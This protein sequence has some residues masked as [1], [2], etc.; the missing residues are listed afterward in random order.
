MYYIYTTVTTTGYGDIIPKTNGEFLMTF[1]FMVGGVTFYSLIYST[2]IAKLGEHMNQN[3]KINEKKSFLRELKDN[4]G[5]F[6]KEY[7]YLYQDMIATIDEYKKYSMIPV[8]TPCFDNIKPSDVD[9]LLLEVC[10]ME[11]R[12][13]EL[14]FL[15]ELPKYLW[16]KFLQ[17][18]EKRVYLPGDVIHYEGTYD[19]NF[20]II[21]RGS[22][23]CITSSEDSIFCPFM[24]ID[25][26][27]GVWEAANI[28]RR[29]WTVI[30]KQKTVI[31]SINIFDFEIIFKNTIFYEPFLM[32]QAERYQKK[33]QANREA[34]RNIRRL[35]R[36]QE[37]FH[38][39]KVEAAEI[40]KETL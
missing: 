33:E 6:R 28:I 34:G 8:I 30:A 23:W 12:F 32:S 37:K 2:I 18:M 16:L 10:Q 31:F 13:H 20:Y 1:L 38:N 26:F 40:I 36:T 21:K 19:S 11:H 5:F 7:K 27:F 9:N 14:P 29:S 3:E 17:V 35:K 4:Y 25:S 39:F 15:K 22:V 24:E